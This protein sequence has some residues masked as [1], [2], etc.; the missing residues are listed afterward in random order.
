MTGESGKFIGR[1]LT[2]GG[3]KES[4]DA[5]RAVVA[6]GNYLQRGRG[7]GP[8]GAINYLRCVISAAAPA[9]ICPG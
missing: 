9:R 8:S 4:K 2:M 1:K 7:V 6:A 5:D 3:R